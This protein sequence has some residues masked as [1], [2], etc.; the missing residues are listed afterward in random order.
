MN[1]WIEWKGG[2]CPVPAETLVD[3]RGYAK[4]GN[5]PPIFYLF[6]QRAD[7]LQWNRTPYSEDIVA[8]RV[9][10]EADAATPKT[11]TDVAQ[12][13]TERGERY[14]K[15]L[16]HATIAQ[17]LKNVINVA[18]ETRKKI[19][20]DDQLEALEMICHK[21]GRILNGDPNYADSWVDIAGYAKLVAD[22][23]QGVE[24]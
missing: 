23:L 3:V 13:L 24:R 6:K 2:E 1:D 8:Y 5:G 15:F 12:I 19:L 14:G 17:D 21:I 7:D 10:K 20:E 11:P 18:L 16:G 4:V 22:R 9:V